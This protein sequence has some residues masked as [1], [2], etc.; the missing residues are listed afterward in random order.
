MAP[1][2]TVKLHLVSI[3]T[4]PMPSHI[5]FTFSAYR[6]GRDA[7]R[8]YKWTV[9]GDKGELSVTDINWLIAVLEKIREESADVEE[10]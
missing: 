7:R 8:L 4:N 6:Q 5:V 3:D 2:G 9:A 1:K 10:G